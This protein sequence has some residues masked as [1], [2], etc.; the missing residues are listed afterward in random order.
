VFELSGMPDI[1]LQVSTNFET[2]N[3]FVFFF[4]VLNFTN[5]KFLMT[6]SASYTLSALSND[7]QDSL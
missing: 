6:C 2:K 3:L 1:D 4:K 5:F 7:A